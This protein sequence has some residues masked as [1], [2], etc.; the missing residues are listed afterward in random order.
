MATS[1]TQVYDLKAREIVEYALEKINILAKGEPLDVRQ[2]KPAVRELNVML[3]EWM[4]YPAIW[5]I[6]EGFVNVAANV[7]SYALTPRPYR[8]ID[9]RFR[10]ASGIDIPMVELTRQEYYDLPRKDTT[11]VPTQWYF[12]PQQATSSVYIWPVPA[13]VTTETLRVTY[14]RFIEDVTDLDQNVDITSEW[15]STLGYNLAARITD[16]YGR[17]GEAINRIIARAEALFDKMQDH[18]RPEIIRFVPERRYGSR[19]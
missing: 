15:L 13:T 10:Q 12:D 17:S 5:R 2:S 19:R 7:G 18:D 16:D 8:I 11:G 14:Q 4:V 3:K 9:M 6:T 1:G